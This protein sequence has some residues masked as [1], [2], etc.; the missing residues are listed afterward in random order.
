MSLA[1]YIIIGLLTLSTLVGMV[2]VLIGMIIARNC[3][4]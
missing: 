1:E 2:N 3:L 4:R